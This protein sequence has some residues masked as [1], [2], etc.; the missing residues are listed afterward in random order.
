MANYLLLI[1]CCSLTNN[2]KKW[3]KIQHN[4]INKLQILKTKLICKQQLVINANQVVLSGR[5]KKKIKST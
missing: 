2:F 4:R 5:V 3:K 1:F